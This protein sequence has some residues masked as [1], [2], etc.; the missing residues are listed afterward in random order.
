MLALLT[1]VRIWNTPIISLYLYNA[2]FIS[3]LYIHNT[4]PITIPIIF[5]KESEKFQQR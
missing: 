2:W 3:V 1:T 5:C 4:F